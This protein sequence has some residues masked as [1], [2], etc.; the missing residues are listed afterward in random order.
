[1]TDT[2]KQSSS[3]TR[4]NLW[5]FV[6]IGL[7]TSLLSFIPEGLIFKRLWSTGVFGLL[8]AVSYAYKMRRFSP[9]VPYKP[10][11]G[12]YVLYAVE[13]MVYPASL[14]AIWLLVYF[15]LYWLFFGLRWLLLFAFP[16]IVWN[17]A[18]TDF[19]LTFVSF[20]LF[21]LLFVLSDLIP[22]S[23]TNQNLFP[24]VAGLRSEYFPVYTSRK[25]TFVTIVGILIVILV[26]PC[27]LFFIYG[28]NLTILY[29]G[30]AIYIWIISILAITPA[31]TTPKTEQE[32]VDAV[33]NL[34]ELAGIR[35]ENNPRT[36]D[37]QIDPLLVGVDY[38]GKKSR[39][40]YV[41]DVI[42]KPVEGEK[43]DYN[44]MFALKQAAWTLGEYYKIPTEDIRRQVVLVDTA[45]DETMLQLS[46]ELN[47]DIIQLNSETMTR[48]LVS[49]QED[50]AKT[51]AATQLLRTPRRRIK[52]VLPAPTST[53][54]EV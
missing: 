45:P 23:V 28:W 20:V 15:L 12:E 34:F 41:I 40:H 9:P 50:T 38:F 37:P 29:V 48:V 44:D 5:V 8:G 2:E 21:Y 42:P 30:L 52:Q 26:V 7:V 36:Q 13:N 33:G 53:M 11:F 10:F 6:I 19:W 18:A 14:G 43:V 3:S 46:Q 27:L 54:G 49:E 35:L 17:I 22:D 4:P 32:T 1:M 31:V 16:S 25:K 51:K 47:I 24:N 39:K